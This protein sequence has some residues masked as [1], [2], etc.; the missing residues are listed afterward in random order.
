ME[1]ARPSPHCSLEARRH[2]HGR[3]GGA[4]DQ[5]RRR[6]C[7]IHRNGPAALSAQSANDTFTAPEIFLLEASI[8]ASRYCSN[9]Y[10]TGL[11]GVISARR[12]ARNSTA[13]AK[14]LA[15]FPLNT[16]AP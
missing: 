8:S 7:G 2:Q 10:F 11:I 13:R 5:D 16:S 3:D 14:V 1:S 12:L 4:L 9:R 6:A 15:R